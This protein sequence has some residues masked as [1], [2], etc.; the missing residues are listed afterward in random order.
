MK[1]PIF[2]S[3]KTPQAMMTSGNSA[4]YP[5]A[6]PNIVAA[7]PPAGTMVHVKKVAQ[8]KPV[9]GVLLSNNGL[10]AFIAMPQSSAQLTDRISNSPTI[11][12]DSVNEVSKDESIQVYN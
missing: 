1:F 10:P 4:V 11:L 6:L 5:Q 3:T 8:S 7:T 12:E 2:Y 9:A